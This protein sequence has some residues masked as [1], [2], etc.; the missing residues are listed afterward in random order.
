M[1][2]EVQ[3]MLK[4]LSFAPWFKF[5]NDF[6]KIFSYTTLGITEGI[7]LYFCSVANQVDYEYK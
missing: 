2:L 1:K 7:T 4:I 5:N 3:S 6:G